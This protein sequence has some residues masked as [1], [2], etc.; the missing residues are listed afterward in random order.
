MKKYFFLAALGAANL[1]SYAQE[2]PLWMRYPAI[3]PD[4]KSIVFSYQGDLYKVPSEGGQAV[5]LTIHEAYD[6]MPVWS[7]DGKWIAFASDRYG[8]MDVYVIPSDGGEAKRLTYYSGSDLPSDFS[9]DN[10]SVLFSSSRI[11]L[12]SNAQIAGMGMSE[13]YSVPVTGGRARLVITQPANNARYSS[14][15]DKIIF[16]D[17]KGFEDPWRK[18]HTSSVT[19]DIWLYE[20]KDKKFTQ[21]TTFNGEDRNPVK[22]TR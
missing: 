11:D 10:K 22:F 2:N 17:Y 6:Y 4:G 9:P 13:L 18:H 5:P 16:H 8:N 20:V 19:R 21:L 12:A 7:H 3:S 15:G 14:S 1:V